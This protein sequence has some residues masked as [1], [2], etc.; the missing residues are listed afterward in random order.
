[1]RALLHL[2]SNDP[3]Q[4][5]GPSGNRSTK[6][7]NGHKRSSTLLV[8]E[9]EI[10]VR[11]P[12]A[13]YLRDSGYRVIEASNA[14]EAQ[15][16]L[17]AG[18]PVELVFSDINMPGMDGVALAK[19]VRREYPGVPVILTSGVSTADYRDAFF[20]PKPYSYETLIVHLKKLLGS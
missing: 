7:T 2:V 11:L 12:V 18:E 4:K 3:S 9:D 5:G 8:V 14:S 6:P 19:W 15:A 1:M 17:Q 10:L 13:D 20:L 16:V